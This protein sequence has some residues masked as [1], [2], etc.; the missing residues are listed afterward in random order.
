MLVHTHIHKTVR[1]LRIALA[2]CTEV[3]LLCTPYVARR[4]L[5]SCNALQIN[6]DFNIDPG[7]KWFDVAD[8]PDIREV[9][10]PKR[11]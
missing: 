5:T 7:W 11:S 4:A 10:L 1:V 2:S 6:C 8:Y 3:T 9:A